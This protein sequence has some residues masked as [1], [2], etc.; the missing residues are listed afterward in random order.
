[1]NIVWWKSL[2]VSAAV[3]ALALAVIGASMATPR[4]QNPPPGRYLLYP[5]PS[6]S[7]SFIFDTAMG[8]LWALP[9]NSKPLRFWSASAPNNTPS[10]INAR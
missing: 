3:A 6:G 10:Q 1:M 2:V 9:V 4:A 5:T 7:G 8:E